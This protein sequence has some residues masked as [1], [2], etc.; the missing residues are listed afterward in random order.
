PRTAATSTP[1]STACST[2]LVWCRATRTS[3]AM[4]PDGLDAQ[5]EAFALDVARYARGA[6]DRPAGH[7]ALWF[8][9]RAEEIKGAAG[10][11]LV[12]LATERI[13][14]MADGALD[15]GLFGTD[16]R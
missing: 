3:L 4:T 16:D 10:P 8:W 6:P 15:A 7:F 12:G 1:G 5:L 11:D 13:I 14:D 9:E 2:R